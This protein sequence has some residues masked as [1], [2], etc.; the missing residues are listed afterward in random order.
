M[1]GA[2]MGC[3]GC[4]EQIATIVDE[5]AQEGGGCVRLL[6]VLQAAG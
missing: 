6:P 3:G 1:C 4:R 5:E 2:G